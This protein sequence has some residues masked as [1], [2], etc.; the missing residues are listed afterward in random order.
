MNRRLFARPLVT[1]AAAF[2]TGCVVHIDPTDFMF[3]GQV[4]D[5]NQQAEREETHALALAPGD[6]LDLGMSYGNV[7]VTASAD[8]PPELRATLRATGRTTAEAE[9]VLA[10]FE[11]L[12]D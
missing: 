10:R 7:E 8:S 1:I 11:V 4:V 5:L 3:D 9:A 2:T 6:V 12:I